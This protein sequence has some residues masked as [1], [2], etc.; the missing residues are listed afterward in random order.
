MLYGTVLDVIEGCFYSFSK[1]LDILDIFLFACSSVEYFLRKSFFWDSIHV[2]Q[3]FAKQEI[4]KISKELLEVILEGILKRFTEWFFGDNICENPFRNFWVNCK[5]NFS[6]ESPKEYLEVHEVIF[7]E[8][9]Q[10]NR[11]L[12]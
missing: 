11:W 7:G 2:F 6:E 9:F 4:G 8:I 10:T 5:S 1:R 3:E 12:E